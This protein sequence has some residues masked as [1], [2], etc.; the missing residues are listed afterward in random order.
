MQTK[1]EK[2]RGKKWSNK[3]TCLT[4]W[5]HNAVVNDY[6]HRAGHVV[7]KTCVNK[8][9]SKVIVGDVAKSLDRINLGSRSKGRSLF[10]HIKYK[11]FKE[12]LI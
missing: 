7:V 11:K 5:R 8:G 12:F 2:Q 6:M 3:L 1:L 10:N 9:I 4:N